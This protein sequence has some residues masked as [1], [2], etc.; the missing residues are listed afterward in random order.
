[1]KFLIVLLTLSFSSFSH[2]VNPTKVLSLGK[3][4]V[5]LYSFSSDEEQKFLARYDEGHCYSFNNI[6]IVELSLMTV[7]KKFKYADTVYELVS[8]DES[9]CFNSS[10]KKVVQEVFKK[11]TEAPVFPNDIRAELVAKIKDNKGNILYTTAKSLIPFNA[12]VE[13]DS[14]SGYGRCEK[15]F[16]G[17]AEGAIECARN[18][19]MAQVTDSCKAAKGSLDQKSIVEGAGKI[20]H[21]EYFAQEYCFSIDAKCESK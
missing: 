17:S 2:A 14:L 13:N 18:Q 5:S 21:S 20:C 3:D 1:M 10:A 8:I 4:N 15:G 16:M 9:L 19:A 7:G 11:P 12:F 6:E